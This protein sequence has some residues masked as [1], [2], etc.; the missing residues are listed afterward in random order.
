MDQQVVG[1]VVLGRVELDP[2]GLEELRWLILDSEMH[3]S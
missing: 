3:L 1:S 2:V